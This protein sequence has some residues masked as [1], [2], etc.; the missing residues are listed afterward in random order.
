LRTV[1]EQVNLTI[2]EPIK[3]KLC[4]P[5]WNLPKC[6]SESET[7]AIALILRQL[8][9]NV[10]FKF[11]A[12]GT[13]ANIPVNPGRDRQKESNEALWGVSDKL[14]KNKKMQTSGKINGGTNLTVSCATVRH[15]SD[16]I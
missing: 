13:A 15:G 16:E 6:L 9:K 8:S 12:C 14:N 7:I 11:L 1:L 3:P 2:Y 10:A 5:I 4:S